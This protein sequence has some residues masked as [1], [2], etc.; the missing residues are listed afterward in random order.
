ML[1]RKDT[2]SKSCIFYFK[3]KRGD[4]VSSG[5]VNKINML[6]YNCY[7]LIKTDYSSL[8][9]NINHI[10]SVT[11]RNTL[12]IIGDMIKCSLIKGV[13]F[14]DYCY[15][16]FYTKEFSERETYIGKAEMYEFQKKLNNTKYVKYFINKNLFNSKFNGYIKRKSLDINKCTIE[17]LEQWLVDKRSII[18]KPSK[19]A[20]GRGI[21]KINTDKFSSGYELL[22]YLRDKKLDL[23]EEV[24]IQNHKLNKLNP[25]SVNT[26]RIMTVLNKE[27]KVNFLGA[28]IR[29]STGKVVDNFN[30]GGI[31]AP[32]DLE[33]GK[34]SGPAVS[35]NIQD[36]KIYYEHPLS[37][38]KIIGFE[39][40]HWDKVIKMVESACHMVPEVRTVGWDV[41]ITE[42]DVLLVEGNHNWCKNFFQQVFGE[43][44]RALILSFYDK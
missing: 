23:L 32:I 30:A 3:P 40:P 6:L 14:S 28:A 5:I 19:G 15:L 10:K 1:K 11:N 25:N 22:K 39:I 16:K 29:M 36:E 21:E 7:F 41:A 34:I 42:D 44:K 27:S 43:G 12:S 24:I 13:S 35:K 8:F 17:G 38:E 9:K 26:I 20:I 4:N 31:A 2:S 37:N 18:A 33:S